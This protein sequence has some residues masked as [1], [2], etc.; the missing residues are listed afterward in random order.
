M[1]NVD[2]L[3]GSVRK[4]L[5]LF[6]LPMLISSIFQQMYSTADTIIVGH[7]LGEQSLAAIGA[8]LAVFELLIGFALGIGSGLS[9]VVARSFGA[10]DT[11]LVKQSVAGSIVIGFVVCLFI[12]LF[13]VT[14][15][16]PLLQVLNTPASIIDESYA[17]ISLITLFVGVMLAYNLCAG[18]LR[19]IGNSVTPLIFLIASSLL[20][21]ALAVWLVPHMGI[22]GAAVATIVSQGSSAVLCIIYI[23]KKCPVLLPSKKHFS[24]S[25]ELYR[26]LFGQGM[27]MGL[28]LSIVCIGTVILQYAINGLGNE[29]IAGHIAAVLKHDRTIGQVCICNRVDTNFGLLGRNHLRTDYLVCDVRAACLHVLS[30]PEY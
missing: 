25:K 7:I 8:S 23:V 6:A 21:I 1:F 20:N 22:V 5:F 13:S 14:Q 4:S 12:M 15:L 11:E 30:E 17:Y 9:I 26:E 19:A 18:F 3:N 24:V 10:K 29:T 27:S 2:M 16:Y 28:M